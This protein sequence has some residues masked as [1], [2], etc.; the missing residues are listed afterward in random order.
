MAKSKPD[1]SKKQYPKDLQR[2]ITKSEASELGPKMGAILEQ[3]KNLKDRKA[4]SAK[5]WQGK[6]DAAELELERLGEAVRTGRIEES[7]L[8]YDEPDERRLEV[9]TKRADNDKVVDR[10]PMTAAERQGSL[11]GTTSDDAE[12]DPDDGDDDDSDDD[13]DDDDD[14]SEGAEG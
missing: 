8:V 2:Q 10:R 7:V 3:V 1:K 11:P 6:I 4:A 12:E 9:V 5:E 13:S 14:D